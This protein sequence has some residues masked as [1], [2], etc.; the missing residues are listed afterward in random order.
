[1]FSSEQIKRNLTLFAMV[2]LSLI[3]TQTFTATSTLFMKADLSKELE[4]SG[5][6]VNLSDYAEYIP[7]DLGEL[8]GEKV[9]VSV[10]NNEVTIGL[11][12]FRFLKIY[13]ISVD[14]DIWGGIFNGLSYIGFGFFFLALLFTLLPVIMKKR[15]KKVSFLTAKAFG[16]VC[17]IVNIGLLCASVAF[18]KG[19]FA[20][21]VLGGEYCKFFTIGISLWGYI[22]ILLN[23]VLI[24][25][26][27]M[28]AGRIKKQESSKH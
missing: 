2:V 1:M 22:L 16:I 23:L 15:Y 8:E 4:I 12:A 6:A 19:E 20:Y 14:G 3:L 11:S 17:F 9:K 26:T 25:T 24:V 27:F 5:V 10:T 7:D 18:F 21:W 28:L 13:S